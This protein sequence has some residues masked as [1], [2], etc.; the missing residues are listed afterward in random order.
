MTFFWD[1]LDLHLE[2]S[3]RHF[4]H[5]TVHSTQYAPHFSRI[6]RREQSFAKEKRLKRISPEICD[7]VLFA[8][9][10]AILILLLFRQSVSGKF[11]TFSMLTVNVMI[12]IM[13]FFAVVVV[14]GLV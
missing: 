1:A 10:L 13:F 9:F 11:V 4:F 6:T 2:A 14:Y 5:T 3:V 8:V 7:V 12:L